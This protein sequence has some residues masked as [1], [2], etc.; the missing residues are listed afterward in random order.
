MFE[1]GAF[2][3]QTFSYLTGHKFL[4]LNNEWDAFILYNIVEM[5][6]AYPFIM[7]VTM[8]AI[9]GIP[10]E[11]IEAT[12]ID[13]ASVWLRFRKVLLPQVMRPVLFATV[14]TTGASYSMDITVHT[15]IASMVLQLLSTLLL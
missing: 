7:T 10:K 14:L 4:I 11:I 12:Y 8:G 6:L 13:G 3:Q 5:W 9:A 1:P 2:L 15:L